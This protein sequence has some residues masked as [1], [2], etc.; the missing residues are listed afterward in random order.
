MLETG[1][2]EHLSCLVGHVTIVKMD[3]KTSVKHFLVIIDSK[4]AS[5]M[6]NQGKSRI[7]AYNFPNYLL[8]LTYL[9]WLAKKLVIWAF[10]LIN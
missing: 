5:M 9:Q 10:Y 6:E 1:S 7:G 2:L 4:E 3:L 8:T